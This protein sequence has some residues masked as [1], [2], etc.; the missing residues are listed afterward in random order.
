MQLTLSGNEVVRAAQGA[1]GPDDWLPI[2]V[3]RAGG[4]MLV[5][6]GAGG[7]TTPTTAQNSTLMWSGAAPTTWTVT[8]PAA[9]V[10]GQILSLGTDTTLT[11]MVTITPTGTQ[12]LSSAFSAQ[13]ITAATSV[14]YQ[15]SLT[16][17]K[18]FRLR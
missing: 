14:E 9:P 13:T 1:G 3:I 15:Y 12:T 5:V 16:A 8:T 11:T 7:V 17:N 2:N 10:D 18:W 4:G 6:S